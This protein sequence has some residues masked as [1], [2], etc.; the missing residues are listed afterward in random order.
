[1]KGEGD[2]MKLYIAGKWEDRS[3]VSDIIRILRGIGFEITCDWTDHKYSDEA[4]PQ[5]YCMD[6]LEGVK[7]ADLYLGI[8][9]ADYHYRGALV[10][11]GIALGVGI[12][13]WLFGDKQDDCIFS[14][15][16]S[17]RKFKAWGELVEALVGAMK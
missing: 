7:N 4:Y 6:D 12:P 1:M 3:R 10:E 11:M 17:V 2:D 5:Q 8:F 13:V 14:H 16:P 15:H 9:V